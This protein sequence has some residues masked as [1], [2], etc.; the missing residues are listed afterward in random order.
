IRRDD[1]PELKKAGNVRNAF[2]RTSGEA[3]VIFDADFCPRPDFLR[4]TL[5]PCLMDPTVGIVQTPQC[6]RWCKDQ[7]WIEKG[8]GTSQEFFFRME[9]AS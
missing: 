2:A 5:L 1:R 6:F 9:Q 8:A 4:E 3:V 7:T